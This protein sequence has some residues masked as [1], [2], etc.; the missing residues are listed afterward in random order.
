MTPG[1]WTPR[2]RINREVSVPGGWQRLSRAGTIGNLEVAA[3][4]AEGP[5][6][7]GFPFLD[8]DA[9]KWLEAVGWT[10]ADPDLP[11][12]V[13]TVLET[14]VNELVDL[15]AA[16]QEPDGYLDSGCVV[17]VSIPGNAD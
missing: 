12:S 15:L 4:R 10:L 6:A 9:Y 5:Y 14:H 2:R 1:W 13:R 11:E 8:S 3:G 7:G 17:T 16:A